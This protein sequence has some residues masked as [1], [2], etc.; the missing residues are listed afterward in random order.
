MYVTLTNTGAEPEAIGVPD[1]DWVDV[2]HTGTPFDVN[3]E[4]TGVVLVGDKPDVREQF[5]RAADVLADTLRKLIALITGRKQH[6][7]DAGAP[8]L[9]T[10]LVSNH[11]KNPVRALLGSGTNEQTVSPGASATLT[12]PGYIELRELQTLDESQTDGGA[13]PAV[14]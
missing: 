5:Q 6:A 9:V 3:D 13:Q 2:L 14:A 8:E 11:G 10:L 7:L 1:G 4:E 12:A